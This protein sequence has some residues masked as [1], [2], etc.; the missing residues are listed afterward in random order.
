MSFGSIGRYGTPHSRLVH[1]L[2]G[3]CRFLLHGLE[4][5]LDGVLVGAG[6]GGEDEVAAVRGALGY[7][8]LVAVFD[9]P[10]DFVHV[11]EVDLRVDA[12]A[13]HVHAQG[14]QVYVAGALTVAEEAAFDPVCAGQVAQFRGGHAGARGH[15]AGAGRG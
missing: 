12:L 7:G 2:A 4:A 14:D 6:E 5:L 9:R 11:G 8:Q 3:G 15:C 10:P 13:E 1:R